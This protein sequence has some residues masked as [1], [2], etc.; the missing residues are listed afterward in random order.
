M[1]AFDKI[2]LVN[3]SG[4]TKLYSYQW[5]QVNT[6]QCYLHQAF[7]MCGCA[8]CAFA[9]KRCLDMHS[10]RGRHIVNRGGERIANVIVHLLETDHP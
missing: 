4:M 2:C 5:I 9:C 8:W 6:C 1:Y 10:K 3:E 7:V